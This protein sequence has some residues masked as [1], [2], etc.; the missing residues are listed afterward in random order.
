[1][2]PTLSPAPSPGGRGEQSRGLLLA[3][4]FRCRCCSCSCCRCCC[5]GFSL[6]LERT[7]HRSG[8]GGEEAHL[9]E[10]SE[11]WA[12]P[13]RREK[14]RGP[15]GAAG[16]FA[17]GAAFFLVT[18]S[19]QKQRKSDS[20]KPRSGWRKLLLLL[21][22]LEYRSQPFAGY[23][24][25]PRA[26]NYRCAPSVRRPR[27]PE[28]PHQRPTQQED[29]EDDRAHDPQR[30]TRVAVGHLRSPAGGSGSSGPVVAPLRGQGSPSVSPGI[31]PAEASMQLRRP[32]A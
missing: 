18:F 27:H 29:P 12:V 24:P 30:A 15:A 2:I 19:L 20:P 1:M 6:P 10:R 21:C 3:Q 31:S 26:T 25:L 11:L 7:E 5:F 13:H 32:L 23:A 8:D 4:Q 17:T 16:R 9:S 28:H 14:R 22:A